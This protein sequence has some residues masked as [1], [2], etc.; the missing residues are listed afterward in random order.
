MKRAKKY[1][2]CLGALI[3]RLLKL[4]QSMEKDGSA[5]RMRLLGLDGEKPI[6]AHNINLYKMLIFGNVKIKN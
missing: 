6:I 2:I 3:I 4:I 5:Q 1:I